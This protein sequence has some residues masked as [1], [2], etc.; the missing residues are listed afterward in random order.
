[1]EEIKITIPLP[2]RTKKNHQQIKKNYQTNKQYIGQSDTYT[3][4][5][6]DCIWFIPGAVR[7]R[8][9]VPVNVKALFYALF[10]EQMAAG[11][12]LIRKIRERKLTI[13]FMTD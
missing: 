8:I 3:Q 12:T 10:Q 6:R 1:M 2:P 9:R 5:E 13:T 4:Y 11:Y 7:K